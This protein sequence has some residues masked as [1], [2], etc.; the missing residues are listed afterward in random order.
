MVELF[1]RVMGKAGGG[2]GMRVLDVG[3]GLGVMAVWLARL[4]H[5]VVAVDVAGEAIRLAR[6]KAREAG[7]VVEFREGDFLAGGVR[8]SDGVGF[9]CVVDRGC[10]HG[11]GEEGE[12]ALFAQRVAEALVKGGVWLN[13]SGSKDHRLLPGE[14][15]RSTYPRLS[16]EEIV[17][18]AER[19]FEVVELRQC[20]FGAGL[21]ARFG[22]FCGWFRKR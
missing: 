8:G 2:E 4:G 7:V 22:A 18:A 20:A 17:R 11:M 16:A 14:A 19:W 6:E 15:E 13:M 12:R 1:G 5:R 21:L 3:C 9:D 10:F